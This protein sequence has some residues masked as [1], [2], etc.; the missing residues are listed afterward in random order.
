MAEKPNNVIL[1][2]KYEDLPGLVDFISNYF[3]KQATPMKINE[4]IID[5]YVRVPESPSHF[6]VPL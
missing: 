6:S 2:E 5:N 3:C 4:P 1:V